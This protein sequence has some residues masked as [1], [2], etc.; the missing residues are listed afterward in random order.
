MRTL[1][2]ALLVPLAALA[3]PLSSAPA[4]DAS[5]P[6]TFTVSATSV[7]TGATL[8]ASGT[9]RKAYAGRK[10]VVQLQ[11]GGSWK[12][13]GK[14]RA[15]A[16]GAY[17]IK[18]TA[19]S[20][21]GVVHLRAS[22][23][24]GKLHAVSAVRAV[25]VTAAKPQPVRSAVGQVVT[26]GGWSFTF[27]ATDT[28]AWPELQAADED[29]VAPAAGWTYVLVPVTFHNVSDTDGDLYLPNDIELLGSDGEYYTDSTDDDSQSCG[30]VPDDWADADDVP[31][32]GSLT[33]NVCAVVPTSALAGGLW[34]VLNDDADVESLV[35]LS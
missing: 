29:N 31:V 30:T 27:G 2:A 20:A 34:S 12:T 25:K 11:T 18:V 5:A 4:A 1:L 26:S 8:T 24:K 21:A 23:T 13:L 9:F 7:S 28:D 32:G 19:P 35:N 15:T 3:A 16:K 10:V 6:A 33:A 22:A 14:G 17:A